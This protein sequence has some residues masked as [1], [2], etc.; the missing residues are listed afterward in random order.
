MS[1]A[2][3]CYSPVYEHEKSI[4]KYIVSCTNTDADTLTYKQTNTQ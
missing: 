2:H 3:C 4:H 1:T